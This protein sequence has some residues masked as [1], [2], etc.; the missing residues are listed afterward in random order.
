MLK[1][2]VQDHYI[3]IIITMLRKITTNQKILLASCLLNLVLKR[4]FF[5]HFHQFLS[6]NVK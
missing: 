4:F 2:K 3:I 5:I 1:Y 6:R